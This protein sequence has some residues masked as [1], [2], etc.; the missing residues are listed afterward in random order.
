MVR[1]LFKRPLLIVSGL[2]LLLGSGMSSANVEIIGAPVATTTI[3]HWGN[4]FTADTRIAVS[5]VEALEEVATSELF[6]GVYDLA[7]VEHPLT[8]NL[9]VEKGLVQFPLLGAPVAVVV[10]LPGVPSNALRLNAQT[11]A[12]IYMGEIVAWNDPR[13]ADINPSLSLPAIPVVPIAQSDGSALTLNMTRYLAGGSD[14]WRKKVGLGSGL[15]WPIGPGEKDSS[16][17]A[18]KLISQQGAIGFQSWSNATKFDLATVRLQNA[19]GEF[20]APT[21]ERFAN[22]F[23]T[24]LSKNRGD[25]DA[26]VNLDGVDAWPVL[27]VVYGQM[28]QIPEDVP[29]A[30]ETVQMLTWILQARIPASDGLIAVGYQDVS[31]ALDQVQ[32]SKAFGPPRK[33]KGA[34]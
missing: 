4:Q 18:K 30:Q 6:V 12:A 16:T 32:S 11:L 25:F 26:P 3:R 22:T 23:R 15:I 1:R 20:V 8:E 14:A 21:P 5:Y 27:A 9:L 7:L 28:K 13:I 17:A 10:N 29:D 24:Y 31:K 34:P 33:R 19:R 2:V